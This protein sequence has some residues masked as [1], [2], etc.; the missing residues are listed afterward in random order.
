LIAPTV[1]A[2]RR[3][4]STGEE[5][6]PDA[7]LN[8]SIVSGLSRVI[9]HSLRARRF[10]AVTAAV[11]SG[12]SPAPLAIS[13]VEDGHAVGWALAHGRSWRFP[14]MD[15]DDLQFGLV[16]V[17]V[18][19]RRSGIGLGIVVDLVVATAADTGHL[20]W[21]CA[22]SN[23]ESVRIAERAGFEQVGQVQKVGRIRGYRLTRAGQKNT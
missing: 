6:R 9:G 10:A 8:T 5:R 20:W 23:E 3:S 7:K 16:Y 1:L 13:A 17:D 12:G 15:S 2:F 4:R 18:R 19:H 22:E 14:F 21:F 11:A